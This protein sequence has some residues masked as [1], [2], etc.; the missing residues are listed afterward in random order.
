MGEWDA[1]RVGSRVVHH[2]S[3]Q[4]REIMAK[5]KLPGCSRQWKIRCEGVE[6]WCPENLLKQNYS[7]VK[8]EAEMPE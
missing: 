7:L 8:E 4:E 6:W 5:R 1:L 2:D 3:G